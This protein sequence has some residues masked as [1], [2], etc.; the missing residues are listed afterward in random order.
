MIILYVI[1][2][3]DLKSDSSNSANTTKEKNLRA[4][5]NIQYK[6]EIRTG[7]NLQRS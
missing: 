2:S 3:H 6:H 7:K 5:V 1:R 4:I